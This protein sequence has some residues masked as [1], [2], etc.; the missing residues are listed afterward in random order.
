[1]PFPGYP[2]DATRT[3]ATPQTTRHPADHN[4][5][6]LALNDLQA[7]VD[8]VIAAAAAASVK[9]FSLRG[10]A[11]VS[12]G[13]NAA[14][15]ASLDTEDLDTDNFHAASDAFVTIP[16]GGAGYYNVSGYVRFAA[17]ATGVRQV[18]IVLGNNAG[19]EG[20]LTHIAG[21]MAFINTANNGLLIAKLL[22][23]ADAA[24]ITL[25]GLQNSGGALNITDSWLTGH[26]V[27]GL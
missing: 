9:A 5:E 4:Q 14:Q 6:R 24:T 23:V 1:M 25:Q 7:Q 27:R 21:G 26:R 13:D 8:A 22:K 11:D 3:N 19:G 2:L 12:A 17:N 10:V 20:N 18:R 15:A 16:T